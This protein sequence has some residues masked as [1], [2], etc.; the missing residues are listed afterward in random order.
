MSQQEIEKL[1]ESIEI[2]SYPNIS[3]EARLE[4]LELLENFKQTNNIEVS[5]YLYS[6]HNYLPTVRHFGL[7]CLEYTIRNHWESSK[8]FQKQIRE[9]IL[10]IFTNT[11]NLL[12]EE[13]YIKQKVVSLVGEIAKRVWPHEWTKLFPELTKIFLLSDT[14]CE[15]CLIFLRSFCEEIFGAVE[16]GDL[17]Y[18]RR[19][20]LKQNLRK[21]ING[22][23]KNI[24]TPSIENFYEELTTTED[25]ERRMISFKIVQAAI[26]SL[27]SILEWSPISIVLREGFLNAFVDLLTINEFRLDTA[28]CLWCLGKNRLNEINRV[29]TGKINYKPLPREH[30]NKILQ[31]SND[32]YEFYTESFEPDNNSFQFEQKF[33]SAVVTITE[34]FANL[35]STSSK[36][37]KEQLASASKFF[38]LLFE[39]SGHKSIIICVIISPFWSFLFKK[40]YRSDQIP[41]ITLSPA[42]CEEIISNVFEISFANLSKFNNSILMNGAQQNEYQDLSQIF[43][44]K[45]LLQEY[46]DNL[47]LTFQNITLRRPNHIVN[48]IINKLIQLFQTEPDYNNNELLLNGKYLLEIHPW[49]S[50][51][52]SVIQLAQGVLSGIYKLK[53]T[54]EI[55]NYKNNQRYNQSNQRYGRYNNRYNK[56]YDRY[57]KKYDNNNQNN[58][59]KD[60]KL[61]FLK[62]NTVDNINELLK[63]LIKYETQD[64]LILSCI[65]ESIILWNF[66][67]SLNKKYV[68]EIY[69]KLFG[70]VIF[71]TGNQSSLLDVTKNMRL[72]SAKS[73]V[74]ISKS[75]PSNFVTDLQTFYDTYR[76][77]VQNDK[78][79][80]QEK[81]YIESSFAEIS[82][83]FYKFDQQQLVIDEILNDTVEA[84]NNENL[85]ETLYDHNLFLKFIGLVEFENEN[86][87]KQAIENR[88]F[89]LNVLTKVN[90]ILSL[91]KHLN[92]FK[93]TDK[94]VSKMLIRESKSRQNKSVDRYFRIANPLIVKHFTKIM[95][96][97]GLI[98]KSIN[99]CFTQEATLVISNKIIH[100]LSPIPGIEL[101]RG[102]FCYNIGTTEQWIDKKDLKIFIQRGTIPENHDPLGVYQCSLAYWLHLIRKRVY[103]L[104]WIAT[105]LNNNEFYQI[106]ELNTFVKEYLFA[107]V[108]SMNTSDL[109]FF[110]QN[111]ITPF[112]LNVP[113][114]NFEEVI[115]PLF[116]SI[117]DFLKIKLEE[118]WSNIFDLETGELA[119]EQSENDIYVDEML[120]DLSFSII[121]ILGKIFSYSI[122]DHSQRNTQRITQRNNQT[123]FKNDN[124]NN[125][126]SSNNSNS[127]YSRWIKQK[128]TLIQKIFDE[129]DLAS[130]I[131]SIMLLLIK[132]PNSICL[133]HT[134]KIFNRIFIF[135]NNNKFNNFLYNMLLTTAIEAL[136]F[137]K[138][139]EDLKNLINFINKIY[140]ISQ[141]SR[142]G[143]FFKIISQLPKVEKEDMDNLKYN[144]NNSKSMKG[145]YYKFIEFFETIIGHSLFG[146]TKTRVID[147]PNRKNKNRDFRIASRRG[148]NN[149]HIPKRAH[150]RKKFKRG[151]KRW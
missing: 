72:I 36:S 139:K 113:V 97:L 93:K 146:A 90:K 122:N 91:L 12:E 20:D 49:I 133:D 136:T 109:A 25:E 39:L 100:C 4:S 95:P 120:L 85:T 104:I 143:D 86:L 114:E 10:H 75:S 58:D 14:Q 42:I 65:I 107:Y 81:I 26:K 137:K 43:G 46:K 128:K 80:E 40:Q 70:L 121:S 51:I 32:L 84:L 35:F 59:Y 135:L 148:L 3:Q 124:N 83:N 62:S 108:E 5:I 112:F 132:V 92:G 77:M 34:G 79:L 48:L 69:D 8:E 74:T 2:Q 52:R 6:T 87:Q 142:K 141:K 129:D 145:R 123:L 47:F 55:N 76:D 73:L 131:L 98:I 44:F 106:K 9:E 115:P 53:K 101:E 149:R 116:G 82:N 33:A 88:S 68:R 130:P 7:H 111:A 94:E 66:Y 71:T 29:R 22:V 30:K 99:Y 27:T 28:E 17:S 105:R 1:V 61:K 67:F 56:K 24:I 45:D 31:L 102:S 41:H 147:N 126:N 11:K 57:N 15:L 117:F 18:K 103:K 54:E 134:I 151:R 127:K 13:R 21:E 64:P 110:I 140:D 16:Y 118:G 60:E 37:P 89:L 96:V 78:L 63:E 38:K 144:L 138:Q 23:F 119:E 150:Y 125:R 50:N 19:V